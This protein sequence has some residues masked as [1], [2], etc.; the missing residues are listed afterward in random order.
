MEA[1][2]KHPCYLPLYVLCSFPNVLPFSSRC[3][4]TG[5]PLLNFWN[6]GEAFQI[7]FYFRFLIQLCCRSVTYFSSLEFTETSFVTQCVI[8]QECTFYC[9][10]VLCSTNAWPV[11]SIFLLLCEPHLTHHALGKWVL[12]QTCVTSRNLG[13]SV[14]SFSYSVHTHKLLSWRLEASANFSGSRSVSL[15]LP[16]WPPWTPCS[17]V[18]RWHTQL[19][20]AWKLFLRVSWANCSHSPGGCL[21]HLVACVLKTF[22]YFDHIFNVI[23]FYLLGVGHAMLI[24]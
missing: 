1:F 10:W 18:L 11:S 24:K 5:F 16:H 15:L 14:S 12:S 9:S 19:F 21:H 23:M 6:F 2:G 13:G 3:F 20:L 8:Y 7:Y 17:T 22:I 4:L